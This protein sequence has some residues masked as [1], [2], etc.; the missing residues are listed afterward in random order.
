VQN[1]N[2]WSGTADRELVVTR[3]FDAP[4]ELV[5]AAWTSPEHLDRW[6][7]PNGFR[8]TVHEIDVRPGGVWR[9]TMHGPNGIDWPNRIV[10]REIVPPERLRYDHG[11]DEAIRFETTVTFV[12]EGERTRLTMRTVFPTVEARKQVDT[13]A[14]EG[15]QQTLGRLDALLMEMKEKQ[16]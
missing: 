15:A 12:A 2:E 7:G 5:F 13:Y 6:W 10:Y 1:E 9:F 3:V 16:S 11:D 4:R 8:N 14:A